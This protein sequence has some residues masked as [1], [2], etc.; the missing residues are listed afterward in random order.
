MPELIPQDFID[1]LVQRI[2]VVEVIGNR[3]EIKKAGKEYKGLCPFHTEKTPSFTVSPDKGFYHCFGCGAHGTALGFLIDFDR[4]TFIEA[5]EELAKMAGVMIPRTKRGRSESV[6]NKN[7]QDLLLELMSHYID[8]L[9]KSKK[10]IEYL[11]TRGIDGQTAKKFSI[12][13]SEDSWDE[14]LK[15]FGTSKKNIENLYDCGLI[16]KKDNGGYYDRFRNRIM[17]P[18][19]S[20][21]GHVLGFGGRIIDQGD[22]KYLNSPET[23]LFKKGELLYGL[24]ESKEFLRSSNHAII[25]EGYTDVISLAHNGFKNSLA[26]LGTA[27][28]DAHIKKAFRFADKITFCFDGDNAGRK[29]AWKACKIC[30]LNIRAN[31]EARFLILPKDQDPDE[32]MQSS[33]P[34]FFKKLL[35]NATPL[36]DFFIETIKKKFDTSRPSGIASAAEYSM[37]P[38]NRIRNGIYKDHLIEKIAS[39]LK[40]KTS[41]LKKFQHQ[42]QTY[43]IQKISL[44]TQKTPST[45]RPSLIRQAINILMH[46]PEVVREISEEKEFKHIHE[47]GID[48]LREIITLIQSNESIKLATIIE[49]FNDQKIKEHLKSMTVEKLIISQMEAKNELHE[50]VLRLNERNTRSELKK[51]VS[52]AKNNALTESERKR[53]LALSKSIEIK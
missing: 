25:V 32:T 10:A 6:K 7:L 47:K 27:T 19:K 44:Q 31:K 46:Y 35:K 38:V 12:G 24:Y 52:K 36:S 51:L 30:L 13:F 14:V 1:D 2:D 9:S 11:K 3:L 23:Q 41:Q 4:L 28:T 34:E 37:V 15:K 43:R 18:I 22:P 5:I 48:I 50:I 21:K 45:H 29:A 20:D 16:I 53:F 26:T 33:G 40:V 39:E 49:H 42:D 17:F 8:N